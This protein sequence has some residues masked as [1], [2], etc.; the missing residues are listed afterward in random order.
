MSKLF[1]LVK[2]IAKIVLI[3]AVAYSTILDE[4]ENIKILYDLDLIPAVIYISDFVVNMGIKISAV[5]MLIG[6]ADYIYQKFKFKKDMKMSKQEV[7]D[8][9]KQQEGDPQVKGKITSKMRETSMR[10]MMQKMPD[11]DVVITNPTHFACAI[12]YDKEKAAAPVLIAKGADHL[13]QKLKDV[14]KEHNVPIVE[15][16]SLKKISIIVK[17]K[18]H[19]FVIIVGDMRNKGDNYGSKRNSSKR[20]SNTDDYESVWR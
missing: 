9:Y 16:Y 3:F 13:A 17:K 4:V 6:L 15:N 5:Y 10:R 8:E 19:L 14:A 18:K 2:S 20:K 12:Q 1:D 7:K 11:A